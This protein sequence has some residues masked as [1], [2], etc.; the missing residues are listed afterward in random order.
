MR[1]MLNPTLVA[2]LVSTALNPALAQSHGGDIDIA[3]IGDP[4]TFDPSASTADLVGMV[5]Q[6]F[7][8]NLFTFGSDFQPTPMLAVE[9]PEISADGLTYDIALR[10]NVLFHDGSSMDAADVV[11]SL[12]RWLAF[13]SRGRQTAERVESIKQTGDYSVR[14][15]LKEPYAPLVALLALNNSAAIIVP[16]EI[17]DQRPLKDLIGTGPY[18]IERHLP[19]QYLQLVRFEGYVAR[20]GGPDGYGGTKHAYLDEI[21]I[22]PIADS[23][24]RVNALIAGDIL[25]ASNLPTEAYEALV[26]A[27]LDPLI[28]SPAGRATIAFN[29]KEGPTSD[30]RVR[31]AIQAALAPDDL[32]RAAF[33]S[34]LFYTVDGAMYPDSYVWHTD[35]GTENYFPAGNPDLARQLLEEAGY[36]GE[37]LVLLTSQQFD[38]QYRIALVAQ[39]QLEAVGLNID[40]QNVEWAALTQIRDDPSAWA[41]R[42]GSSPYLAEPALTIPPDTSS[43]WW[44]TDA[45]SEVV[46]AFNMESDP[47]ARVARHADF[48]V[49]FYQEVPFYIVGSFND[50]AGK[51]PSLMGIEPRAWPFFWNAWLER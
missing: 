43:G 7:F 23:S 21:R 30:I 36:N 6:H 18:R 28:N 25:F 49:L 33:G 13:A 10:E 38:F 5:T 40:L 4:P 45:K 14:I 3:F 2:L 1:P 47:D 12:E 20:D 19:D 24:T 16:E 39:Q 42:T 15:T 50:L 8:E 34:E 35:A 17:A 44:A 26:D 29:M 27:N 41:L 46:A 48:Q 51:S 9:M 22:L 11:A 32:M 31:R 37:Q